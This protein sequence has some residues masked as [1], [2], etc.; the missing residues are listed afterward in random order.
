MKSYLK[1]TLPALAIALILPVYAALSSQG[2]SGRRGAEAELEHGLLVEKRAAMEKVAAEDRFD[3]EDR[4][5]H[6]GANSGSGTV[7]AAAVMEDR[8]NSGRGSGE[9]EDKELRAEAKAESELRIK[10][11][12]VGTATQV[13]IT[14]EVEKSAS[15]V[16]EVIDALKAMLALDRTAINALLVMKNVENNLENK[17]ESK[18]EIK[19]GQGE[20]EVELRFPV[21][22]TDRTTIIN[23]IFEKLSALKLE[24]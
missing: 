3:N 11:E 16:K 23:A 24:A 19:N 8:S 15:T 20:G 21:N 13:K 14:A 1:Y 2:E 7:T 4:G 12:T 6:R 18:A 5:Q 22:S 10:A 9:D 17:F